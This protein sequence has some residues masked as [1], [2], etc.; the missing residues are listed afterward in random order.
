MNDH[1]KRDELLSSG[2]A[3][4]QRVTGRLICDPLTMDKPEAISSEI[5]KK[6]REALIEELEARGAISYSFEVREGVLYAS[7]TL[8]RL[9]FRKTLRRI[10]AKSAPPRVFRKRRL[11]KRR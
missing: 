4:I 5:K 6:A 11:S 1:T 2:V 10:S 3:L 8:Y 9:E 7:M